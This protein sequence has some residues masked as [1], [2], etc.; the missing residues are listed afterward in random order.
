MQKMN[1]NIQMFG[2][3]GASSTNSTGNNVI[4]VNNKKVALKFSDIQKGDTFEIEGK[5]GTYKMKVGSE[6]RIGMFYT[7]G[8]DSKGQSALTT[9]VTDAVYKRA[10]STTKLYMTPFSKTK[11][12]K[13]G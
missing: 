1:L 9:L 8:R 3:R 7:E 4:T 2:G 13:R 5:G 12:W 11:N 10:D 6:M